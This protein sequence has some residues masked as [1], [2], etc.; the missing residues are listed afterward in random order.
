[1]NKKYSNINISIKTNTYQKNM[2][3]TLKILIQK[4]KILRDQP[5]SITLSKLRQTNYV[6]KPLFFYKYASFFILMMR[7]LA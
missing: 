2:M 7:T 6:K 5:V 1:M 4:L 3:Q